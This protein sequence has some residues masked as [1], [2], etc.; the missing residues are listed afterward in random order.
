MKYCLYAICLI[1]FLLG[2]ED[3]TKL[4][5]WQILWSWDTGRKLIWKRDAVSASSVIIFRKI[6]NLIHHSFFNYRSLWFFWKVTKSNI[7]WRNDESRGVYFAAADWKIEISSFLV[8]RWRTACFIWSCSR[9]C[10][11]NLLNQAV[12]NKKN[13]KII[14]NA[15]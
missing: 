10:F 1:V 2:Q 14:W 9:G 15:L 12:L 8:P 7:I 11:F 3:T 5:S 6:L 13:L 4:A